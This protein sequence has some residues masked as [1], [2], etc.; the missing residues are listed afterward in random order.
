MLKIFLKFS[1][2]CAVF[3]Y[4]CLLCEKVP[5][6]ASHLWSR[7]T[8][9]RTVGE[10]EYCLFRSRM[11]PAWV[12]CAQSQPHLRLVPRDAGYFVCSQSDSDRKPKE[13]TMKTKSHNRTERDTQGV[14]RDILISKTMRSTR[15]QFPVN[16]LTSGRLAFTI[17]RAK[18]RRRQQ[19]KKKN[20]GT[21]G[22]TM[23]SW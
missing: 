16:W 3:S 4:L 2:S 7:P 15:K 17:Q 21:S 6:W 1:N 5:A 10:Y 14:G 22:G 11:W 19:I 12:A 20:G 13:Y 8:R 9:P 18:A 23:W